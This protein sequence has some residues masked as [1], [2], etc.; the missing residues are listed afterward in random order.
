MKNFSVS[1][2]APVNSFR[3]IRDGLRSPETRGRAVSD[4]MVYLA[5]AFLRLVLLLAAGYYL[6]AVA[7][8]GIKY[9]SFSDSAL[10]GLNSRSGLA[11]LTK[12]GG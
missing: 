6:I 8:S 5:G 9:D 3:E 2:K 1:L 4:L 10:S 7:V 11:K 12:N